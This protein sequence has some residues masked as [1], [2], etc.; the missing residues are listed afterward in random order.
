MIKGPEHTVG[1]T[2]LNKSHCYE[3]EKRRDNCNLY[4]TAAAGLFS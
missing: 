2:D 3:M 1:K 4:K